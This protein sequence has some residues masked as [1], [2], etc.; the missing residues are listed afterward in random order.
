M[1]PVTHLLAPIVLIAVYHRWRGRIAPVRTLA[2]A[3]FFGV[4]PDLLNLHIS[5]AARASW[6]HSLLVLPLFLV[7]LVAGP[8]RVRQYARLGLVGFTAHIGLDAVSNPYNF[9]YPLSFDPSYPVLADCGLSTFAC[10]Y[11]ADIVLV[12]ALLV[13]IY[14]RLDGERYDTDVGR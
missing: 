7:G 9:L 13:L 8:S 1:L 11:A 14:L 4:L 2:I 10:W 12:L 5:L 3:G 6:S